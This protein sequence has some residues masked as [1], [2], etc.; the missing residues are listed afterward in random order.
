MTLFLSF[1]WHNPCH[2]RGKEVIVCNYLQ[3]LIKQ[4]KYRFGKDYSDGHIFAFM[5]CL[6]LRRIAIMQYH[7]TISGL[8][9]NQILRRLFENAQMQGFRNPEERGVHSSTSQ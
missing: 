8:F 2:G 6:R 5:Q 3:W 1:I 7:K 9:D 4:G